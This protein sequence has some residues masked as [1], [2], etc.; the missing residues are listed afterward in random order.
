MLLTPN[1]LIPIP[2][3]SHRKRIRAPKCIFRVNFHVLSLIWW[4]G[5]EISCVSP[6]PEIVDEEDAFEFDD[7][8]GGR[9]DLG[10]R[11]DGVGCETAIYETPDCCVGG[12]VWDFVVGGYELGGVA[13]EDGLLG[14]LLEPGCEEVVG[15]GLLCH[16][17]LVVWLRK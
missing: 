3:R 2:R 11:R 15:C 16:F 13:T 5:H 4:N 12:G 17:A 1:P 6:G 9:E 14:W 10:E 8:W 7:V